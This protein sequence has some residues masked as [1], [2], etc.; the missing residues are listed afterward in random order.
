M[1]YNTKNTLESERAYDVFRLIAKTEEGSYSS[2]IAEELGIDQPTVSEIISR[3]NEIGI[4]EKNEE[5]VSR[6]QYYKFSSRDI[7]SVFE[8]LWKEK[9]GLDNSSIEEISECIAED[10]QEEQDAIEKNLSLIEDVEGSD[11]ISKF[12][13]LYVS[14]YVQDIKNSKIKR[15]LVDDFASGSYL[16][17][18]PALG[19]SI[20]E[21]VDQLLRV[22]TSIYS[23]EEDTGIQVMVDTLEQLSEET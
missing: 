17:S 22:C 19:Y 20:P 7:S 12:L 18:L 4:I 13:T 11:E 21:E 5:K 23:L 10:I 15:M 6:A 14:N 9:I 3:L 16:Q 2:R 8:S 1:S